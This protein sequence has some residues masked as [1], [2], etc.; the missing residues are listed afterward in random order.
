MGILQTEKEYLSH[1]TSDISQIKRTTYL[2]LHA[3]GDLTKFFYFGYF[4]TVISLLVSVLILTI[5]NP[6]FTLPGILIGS[7]IV[8]S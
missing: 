1:Q 7:L 4:D 8:S 3:N 6:P 2:F 5:P